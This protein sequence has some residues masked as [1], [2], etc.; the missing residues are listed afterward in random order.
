MLIPLRRN[1]LRDVPDFGLVDLF[2]PGKSWFKCFPSGHSFVNGVAGKSS[3]ELRVWKVPLAGIE[4]ITLVN[5]DGAVVALFGLLNEHCLTAV[6][7][8]CP[9]IEGKNPSNSALKL[10]CCIV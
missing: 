3:S 7:V 2:D 9:L 10:G 4:A 5:E 6:A 8:A 1:F